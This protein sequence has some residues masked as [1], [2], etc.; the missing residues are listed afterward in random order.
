MR[1]KKK[2]ARRNPDVLPVLDSRMLAIGRFVK[3][4]LKTSGKLTGGMEDALAR[5]RG[6][7]SW[8]SSPPDEEQEPNPDS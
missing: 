6:D 7:A 1:E 2:S 4:Y 8:E 3:K 5:T